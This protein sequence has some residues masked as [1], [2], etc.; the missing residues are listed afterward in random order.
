MYVTYVRITGKRQ[1]TLGRGRVDRERRKSRT[2][3][4]TKGIGG[5]KGLKVGWR[6][7]ETWKMIAPLAR[8]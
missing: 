2:L 8:E 6:G 5:K 7:E 4:A 1:K 3:F